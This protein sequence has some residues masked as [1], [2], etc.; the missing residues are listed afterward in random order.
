MVRKEREGERDRSPRGTR[1]RGEMSSFAAAASAVPADAQLS[2]RSRLKIKNTMEEFWGSNNC[3]YLP[4]SKSNRS[5]EIKREKGKKMWS[6][7]CLPR[8]TGLVPRKKTPKSQPPEPKCCI[9]RRCSDPQ[10]TK[11]DG[12]KVR[13][14]RCRALPVDT[15]LSNDAVLKPPPPVYPRPSA[16]ET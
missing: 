7:H 3:Y 14:G 9:P 2:D 5:E 10:M 16:P 11:I 13:S 12:R 8:Q 15:P 1:E 6:A 4:L